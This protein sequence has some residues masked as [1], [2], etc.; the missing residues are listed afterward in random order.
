MNSETERLFADRGS[1]LLTNNTIGSTKSHI[2]ERIA[3]EPRLKGIYYLIFYNPARLAC[4]IVGLKYAK[5]DIVECPARI[6]E[7]RNMESKRG[8]VTHHG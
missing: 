5:L 7:D 6:I 3:I 2:T 1:N 8:T 4:L